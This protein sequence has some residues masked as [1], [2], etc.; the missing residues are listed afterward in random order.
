MYLFNSKLMKFGYEVKIAEI[1]NYESLKFFDFRREMNPK[2]E[3]IN[4]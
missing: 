3:S 4:G 1:R 2:K